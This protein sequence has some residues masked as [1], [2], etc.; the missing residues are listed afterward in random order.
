ML[1]DELNGRIM[2]SAHGGVTLVVD[3]I[4]LS[5]EDLAAFLSTREGSE[6]QLRIVDG[7]E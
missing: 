5:L 1:H 4:A 3:G 7:I 6:F 2:W